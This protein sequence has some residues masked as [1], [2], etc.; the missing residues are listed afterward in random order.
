[1]AGHP[2]LHDMTNLR[3]VVI[4]TL[5]LVLSHRAHAQLWNSSNGTVWNNPTSS[6]VST[7]ITGNMMQQA[8]KD[9]FAQPGSARPGSAPAAKPHQPITKTD[10]APSG[11]RVIVDALIGSLAKTPDQRQALSTGV[12]QVFAVYEQKVRKNNVAYAM[13][14]MAAMAVVADK[15]IVMTDQQSENLAIAFND[16]LAANPA[17]AK[18]GAL[19][20]Q[21]VYETFVTVGSLI[22]LFNEVGKKDPSS[23]AAAKQLA[24]E[25]Y[26][27][28]GL[29]R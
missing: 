26:K 2:L 27:L 10:F 4:A 24:G 17:F 6:L 9:S 5:V 18:A 21:K 23:A 29:N 8:M 7:M 25:A 1:M 22:A 3:S 14:F 28:L 16:Q 11:K 15:G 13:A 19:D 12:A 20:R